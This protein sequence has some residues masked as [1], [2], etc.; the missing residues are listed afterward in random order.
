MA[1]RIKLKRSLTPNSAPTTSDLQ[2]KEVAL[3]ITDRTLFVNNNGTIQEVLN[4]DPN[5]E[6]IVPSM[7]SSAITN[8]VGNTW[9]VSENGTDKATLG[10]V[11]PR[12]GSTTGSNGWGRTPMTAFASVKYCLDNYATDGDT[13]VI[14]SGTYTETFPLTVPVGVSVKGAGFKT[15]FIKPTV[16]TNNK[17][18]FLIQGNCNIEDI[19]VIDFYY[20]SVNNT[21]YAFRTK[22]G[23]T[24]SA[25]GRRPYVQRCSVITKGSVTSGSD[26][27]GYA[28]GD[29]G[30]G[31]LIDGGVVATNSAEASILFNES[32]FIVPNSVGLYLKNGARC[33]W[34][35]SF[36][37][38]AADSVIGENPGGT[39]FA[40]QGRARLKL[41]GI[42]G[43]FAAG[44]TITQYAADGTTVLASGTIN[45]NDGTYIYITGQGTGNFVEAL[46]SSLTAKQVTVNGDAQIDVTI[47]KIGNSSLKLDGTGDYL[48]L[49]SSSDFGYNTGNFTIEFWVR[50]DSIGNQI[51]I[52]QRTASDLNKPVVHIEG[53]VFKFFALGNNRVT[54]TTSVAINTW[55]HVAVVKNNNSTKLY[56][57]GAQE[58]SAYTDN[59]DYGSSSEIVIGARFSGTDS[60]PGYLDEVRISKGVSRYTGTFTPSTTAFT[61]DINTSLLL[62]FEGLDGSTDI[63]DGGIASQ[64][65]RTSAGGT[66]NFVTLADYT[67]FGAELRSI[68]SASIYGERGLTANGKGVRLYCIT[69]NFSYIGTGKNQ[70]NDISQVNQANE[71]IETNNGRALFTSVD[72]NGDFRVGNTF[73]VDQERGT[74]SFTGSGGTGTTFDQLTVTGSGNVTT[75]L[76]TSISVGNLEFSGS[77]IESSVS[78]LTLNS[79][80]YTRILSNR[81]LLQDGSFTSPSLSFWNDQNTGLSRSIVN[82][83]SEDGS[84]SLISNGSEK[85]RISESSIKSFTTSEII[86]IGV[87]QNQE[88]INLNNNGS[89][90][91]FGTFNNVPLKGGTGSGAKATIT[92]SAFSGIITNQG[93]GYQTGTLTNIPLT[94]NGSGV[95]GFVNVSVSGIT[96]TITNPGSGYTNNV[97][98]AIPLRNGSG[99]GAQATITVSGGIVT[100]VN[101]TNSGIGYAINDILTVNNSDLLYGAP[102]TA[103]GGSG[104][105]FTITPDENGDGPGE[106]V[107]ITPVANWQG[108]GYQAGN[109][110]GLT[111]TNGSG[112]SYTIQ[113]SGRITNTSITNGGADYQEGDILTPDIQVSQINDSVNGILRTINYY[114]TVENNLGSPVFGISTTPNGVPVIAPALNLFRNTVYNFIFTDPSDFNS[115]PL[116]F[117]TNSN[118]TRQYTAL[119]KNLSQ[120]SGIQLVID[121]STVQVV[122]DSNTNQNSIDIDLV[123]ASRITAGASIAGPG[124][125]NG[126]VIFSKSGNRIS[127]TSQTGTNSSILKGTVLTVTLPTTIYYYST[128]QPGMG[129]SATISSIYGTGGQVEVLN[130]S[131]GTTTTITG[132]NINSS[133][134]DIAGNSNFG[135][136]AIT[137]NLS[138]SNNANVIG[139]LTAGSVIANTLATQSTFST[140]GD[141]VQT[142]TDNSNPNNVITYTN[143]AAKVSPQNFKFVGVKVNQSYYDFEVNGKTK[144]NGSVYLATNSQSRVGIGIE[145]TINTNTNPPTVGEIGEKLE[146]LGN[147]KITGK[148]LSSDGT[149]NSP[150]ITFQDDDRLGFYRY[151]QGSTNNLGIT[152]SEGK[153]VSLNGS[154]SVFH[155]NLNFDS[156]IIDEFTLTKGSKYTTGFYENVELQGGTGS[157]AIANVTIA[158]NTILT[159]PG[160]GYTNAE[161][162]DVPVSYAVLPGGNITGFE[163]LQGGSGYVNGTYTNVALFGGSG[164]GATANFTVTN[165]IVTNAIINSGGSGYSNT[166]AGLTVNTQNIG[167]SILTSVTLINGGT[168]YYNGSYT[169][170][171]ITNVSSNGSNGTVNIVVSNGSISSVTVNNGG[172]GY[173]TSDQFT[174][175]QQL[176]NPTRQLVTSVTNSGTNDFVFSGDITGNDPTIN[177]I[178]GDTITF[179]VNATGHPFYI[180][181][182]LDNGAYNSIYQVAT[183]TGQ[184]TTSG[185]VFFDTGALGIS[186]GTYYY[187]CGSHS[188]MKGSIIISPSSIGSGLSF[189]ASTVSTG[190]GF[191]IDVA[192]TGSAGVQGTGATAYVLVENGLVTEFYITDPGDENYQSGNILYVSNSDMTYLDGFG[193]PTQSATPTTQ[194]R[195]T[196]GENG[197]VTF[198]EITDPGNGYEINDVLSLPNTF[199]PTTINYSSGLTVS[200]GQ[201]ILASNRIYLVSAAGILGSS[202]PTHTTG[203]ASNGSATLNFYSSVG[204]E[205]ELLVD[206]LSG[207]NTIEIDSGLGKITA[208]TLNIT[209]GSTNLNQVQVS[210]NRISRNTPGNLTIAAGTNGFVEFEGASGIIVPKGTTSQRPAAQAG[211]IRYNTE[212]NLFEGYN[213]SAFVSLGGVRDVD[214]N[215]YI[216]PE[217]SPGA[218][219]NILYFY[220]DGI[221]VQKIHTNLIETNNITRFNVQNLNGVNLWVQGLTVVSPTDPITFNPST[222]V[223]INL[224]TI[225]FTN[226]TFVNGQEVTYSPGSGTSIGPLVSGNSYYISVV[227]SNTIKLAQS[228]TALSNNVFIDI[229]NIGTGNSHSLTKVNPADLLYYYG[230][231]VYK[232]TSSGT[233]NTNSINYPQHT[234]GSALNG[235]ANLQWVRKSYSNA[236]HFAKIYNYNVEEFRINNKLIVYNDLTETDIITSS[237]ELA[238]GFR[239]QNNDQKL[240][241]F[242]NDGK[243]QVNTSFGSQSENYVTIFEYDLKK[244]YLADTSILSNTSTIN[245]SVGNSANIILVTYDTVNSTLPVHSGKVMIEIVDNS[246]IAKRQYSELSFLVKSDESDII[247]TE[248]NKLY[249]N[250]VLCDVSANLDSSKNIIVNVVDTTGSTSTIYTIK[251]VSQTILS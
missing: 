31:V 37:Y 137:G 229:A 89:L 167:G 183:V 237:D 190:S 60:L 209:T 211:T 49:A 24:V 239:V 233:F 68:G 35:N 218:N 219:D 44:N 172:K 84:F 101:I 113:S 59:N 61:T 170:L 127:L 18:A 174:V 114:V 150:E 45:Q 97:Y 69:H 193:I 147:I 112:F 3:N 71:V 122:V 124:I 187:V 191:S 66:A 109:T 205:F 232:I 139:T 175:S 29:A 226:H 221:E 19:A 1:T 17:D 36:T 222:S 16:G 188:T 151:T 194:F 123:D 162:I 8:G 158:F 180:V 236:D 168:G 251:V 243:V 116:L 82:G 46:E 143:F 7:F 246:P 133:T 138:V 223:D 163:N 39:G 90:Y 52:D 100:N 210:G 159:N 42:T 196:V 41:N 179:N 117:S 106:V 145:P 50:R 105:Q 195:A 81:L 220:A 156:F 164:V 186:P 6:T 142:W 75:I 141:I 47:K 118:N 30:R 126:E 10:S 169:N 58:G 215:T 76:P 56:V 182:Q 25:S 43:T 2:D 70:D 32:T 197:S 57:N 20:D 250:N 244:L 225:T 177:V 248:T 216:I 12:H 213:G 48:S 78:S 201:Y 208:K 157:G 148:Y 176:L 88:D 34:L 94:T 40:G 62:Q 227:N 240:I 238:H 53:G 160:S 92:T 207:G 224:N 200:T 202:A 165:G 102:P 65:I 85:L 26:P 107:T 245:T 72:Q 22:S 214:L 15:T 247:Y 242:I 119:T 51:I 73:I 96:G 77:S 54:G 146:I 27:R 87:G 9:Y 128:I 189:N 203:S 161:Y 67:A 28:Q 86:S 140:T 38:F 149:V 13:V 132:S 217:S 110:I 125:P 55:Y 83:S 95:N 63:I 212:E 33:E 103:S 155:K 121:S 249:T 199:R 154:T 206:S 241:K 235:T 115:Y 21:G 181:S 111:T 74:V 135:S 228:L 23:Y 129:N 5:D 4:A 198:V 79:G 108:I 144:T 14:A 192:S 104:F 231:N 80:D 136:T 178:Q 98:S 166:D 93:S 134:I 230:E 204:I 11:N 99:N 130:L 171:P 64:D 234:S 131:S 153:I 91:P 184:G 120:V 173:S 152:S 185:S